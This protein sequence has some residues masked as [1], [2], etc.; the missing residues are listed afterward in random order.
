MDQLSQVMKV[1]YPSIS[2]FIQLRTSITVNWRWNY[3][4]SFLL[5]AEKLIINWHSR[6]ADQHWD[7]NH[8]FLSFCYCQHRESFEWS[9]INMSYLTQMGGWPCIRL[10][11]LSPMSFWLTE[12]LTEKANIS[13]LHKY[14]Y[15]WLVILALAWFINILIFIFI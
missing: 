6:R 9:R 8:T 1:I 11:N 14:M 13:F 2:H 4:I 5:L 10:V 12:E 3:K 7:T 15:M